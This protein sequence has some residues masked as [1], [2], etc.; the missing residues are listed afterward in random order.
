[1]SRIA[2]STIWN[3]AGTGAPALAALLGVP[4]LL[5]GLGAAR[6]GVLAIAWS[7]TGYLM[8][9]NLGL[10]RATIWRLV[11]ARES[12]DAAASVAWTSLAAHGALGLCA[13]TKPL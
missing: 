1:V 12:P 8:L 9:V 2:R 11:Q 13:V 5:H 6:F 3:V 7:V 10:G 4:V